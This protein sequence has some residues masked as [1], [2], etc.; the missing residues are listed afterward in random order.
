MYVKIYIYKFNIC[1]IKYINSFNSMGPEY[2]AEFY[3]YKAGE[4]YLLGKYEQSLDFCT[5]AIKL[6][7][8]I[9]LYYYG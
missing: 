7:P 9:Y 8:Q 2:D 6:Q 3:F 1:L 5:K 4:L